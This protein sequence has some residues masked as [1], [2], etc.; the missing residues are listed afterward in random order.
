MVL[1]Q[2]LD[3]LTKEQ[4]FILNVT[5][6]AFFKSGKRWPT[7]QYVEATLDRERLDARS[8]LATFPVAG[9]SMRYAAFRCVP[10]TGSLNDDTKIDLTVL[11]LHHYEGAFK[12]EAETLVRDALRL[13]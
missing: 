10:W 2:L 6:E 3:P 13:L 5:A 8:V 4:Q 11:G 7:Y 9:T 12:A 1:K